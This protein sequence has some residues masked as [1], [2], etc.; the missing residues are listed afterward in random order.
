MSQHYLQVLEQQEK[1]GW[2]TLG[3]HLMKATHAKIM[4]Y[5]TSQPTF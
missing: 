1:P 5:I 2:L 3:R 4:L